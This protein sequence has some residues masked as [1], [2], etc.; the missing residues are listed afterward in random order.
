MVA[1]GVRKV[2]SK[3]FEGMD[4]PS[5]QIG[6]LKEILSDLGM[7]GRFSLEQA[8]SIREKRELAQELGKLDSCVY[9]INFQLFAEDVQS[10]E[11]AVVGK[12]RGDRQS[13]SEEDGGSPG[14]KR[15]K[16]PQSTVYSDII[17][18]STQQKR[19]ARQSIMAFLQ[20]QSG[21]E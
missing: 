1:C 13:D 7:K 17:L 14:P 8:K 3:V 4:K 16:V 2:W 21:S 10:F 12:K 11:K 19:S 5:Q 20:S 6:K 18:M 15:R 9:T